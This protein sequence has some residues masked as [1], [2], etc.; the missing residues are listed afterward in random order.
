M[1]KIRGSYGEIGDD[2][3]GAR[4]MYMTQW[5]YG[6]NTSL[7]VTQGTS[8]YTWY[9][10]TTV[11][12][13]AARAELLRTDPRLHRP[14][15]D[16][17]LQRHHRI[18]V[19]GLFLPGADVLTPRFNSKPTY[20]YGTQYLCDGSYI[21]LKNVE[22]AHFDLGDYRNWYANEQ[23]YLHRSAGAGTDMPPTVPSTCRASRSRSVPRS[24]LP[25][26]VPLPTCCPTTGTTPPW[27]RRP[28]ART[29]SASPAS[30][31]WAIW[32]RC[33]CGLPRR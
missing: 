1:L 9:R 26:S 32:A 17:D 22:V 29:T 27:V 30:A 8:P 12:N 21:R 14:R 7:D 24:A 2:N 16:A 10:E 31:P 11:G 15:H 3:V 6:G 13:L 23:S 19:E 18:R 4:F 5:A 25:I 20:Y 28:S 33:C